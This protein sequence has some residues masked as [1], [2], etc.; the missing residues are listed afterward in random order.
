MSDSKCDIETRKFNFKKRLLKYTL[1]VGSVFV[2][3]LS[4]LMLFGSESQI[5]SVSKAAEVILGVLLK[6]LTIA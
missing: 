1:S 3:I 6:I 5:E 2:A 4:Y